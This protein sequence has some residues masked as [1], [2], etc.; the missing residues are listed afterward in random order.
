MYKY[1]S[2]KEGERKRLQ[3]AK[4]E[5]NLRK[6]RER[7]YNCRSGGQTVVGWCRER[8]ISSKAYYQWQ[9]LA[10]AYESGVL[11][12]RAAGQNKLAKKGAAIRSVAFET[13]PIISRE[14][15]HMQST[16]MAI[17]RG[18]W[19]VKIRDGSDILF[20][21]QII[22]FRNGPEHLYCTGKV[23]LCITFRLLPA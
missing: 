14:S 17:C 2:E 8:G 21:G 5:A 11:T 3:E 13:V 22:F 19:A 9:K 16:G 15:V 12:E 18:E 20:L 6:R 1:Q 23:S 4:R 7:V 10:W